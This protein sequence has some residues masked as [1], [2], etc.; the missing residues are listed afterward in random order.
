MLPL[1]TLIVLSS[2]FSAQ[3]TG[4]LDPKAEK[5]VERL[6]AAIAA[7]RPADIVQTLHAAARIDDERVSQAILISLNSPILGVQSASLEALRFQPNPESL[8]TLHKLFERKKLLEDNPELHVQ[9]FAG[10]RTTGRQQLP[11][12]PLERWFPARLR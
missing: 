3:E 6:E 10:H 7:K 2:P 11:G 4:A 12:T 9:L 5:R 1:L 8:E